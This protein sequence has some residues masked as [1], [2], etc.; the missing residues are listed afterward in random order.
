MGRGRGRPPTDQAHY[1]KV[2]AQLRERVRAG[3]YQVAKALPPLRTLARTFKVSQGVIVPAVKELKREGLIVSGPGRR[4]FIADPEG[5]GEALTGFILVVMGTG[6]HNLAQGGIAVQALQGI[7]LGAGELKAPIAIVHGRELRSALPKGLSALAV[8]GIVLYGHFQKAVLKKYEA[9]SMP[10]VFCD[11]PRSD[12]NIHAVSVNNVPEAFDATNRLLA[13]GHR[14]ITFLRYIPL[15]HGDVDLDSKERQ[16]GFQRAMEKAG[17]P[18]RNA[19]VINITS[20]DGP[21]SPAIQNLLKARNRCSAVFAASS[22]IADMVLRAARTKRIKVPG[23]LSLVSFQTAG[24]TP[25]EQSGQ[26]IDFKKIGLRA[27]QLIKGPKG[28]PQQIRISSV[29]NKGKTIGAGPKV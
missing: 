25:S 27:V 7:Q 2:A 22:L 23:D 6:L 5:G 13:L 15:T 17:L 26:Q 8:R 14:K 24:P 19:K 10:V 28:P 29:W 11:H 21:S 1:R 16:E 20:S 3:E 18:K 9:L 4:L 12:W